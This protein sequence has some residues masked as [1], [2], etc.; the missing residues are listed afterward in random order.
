VEEEEIKNQAVLEEAHEHLKGFLLKEKNKYNQGLRFLAHEG[1]NIPFFIYP[2]DISNPSPGQFYTLNIIPAGDE[3]HFISGFFQP[4][5]GTAQAF[6][7]KSQGEESI[8]WLRLINPKI[9]EAIDFQDVAVQ[10][11]ALD[12]GGCLFIIASRDEPSG[13]KANTLVKLNSKGKE[14]YSNRIENTRVPRFLEYDQINENILMAFKGNTLPENLEKQEILEVVLADSSGQ[15]SWSTSLEFTGNLVDIIKVNEDY[16]VAGNFSTL[17]K[18]D[19]SFV[20]LKGGPRGIQNNLFTMAIGKNG[21]IGTFQ[22]HSSKQP[23]YAVEAMKIN[24]ELINLLGFQNVRKDIYKE[25]PGKLGNLFYMLVRPD[26]RALYSNL[27]K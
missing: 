18:P 14:T 19:G 25:A 16:L 1:K 7:A 4:A 24:S 6:V 13:E 10:T 9:N 20:S 21:T 26:G 27:L 8:Q 17:Q 2:A 22:V 15:S 11:Q 23:F 3:N 5:E 12:K